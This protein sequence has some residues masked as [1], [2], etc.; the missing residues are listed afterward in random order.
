MSANDQRRASWQQLLAD[1]QASGL[2]VTAW[3]FAQDIS[4][5]TFYYWRRRL[6]MS[7]PAVPPSPQ[8]LAIA[9][10]EGSG[11]LLTLHV[12]R[13]AIDVPAGF[14]PRLLAEVLTVLE[15]R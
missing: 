10:A 15:G 2:S 14:D 7:T 4:L 9:P 3:C 11:T 12:G 13:V 1:Q 5:Q 6:N 8:W